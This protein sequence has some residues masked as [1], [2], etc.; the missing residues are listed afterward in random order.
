MTKSES[1]RNWRKK[2]LIDRFRKLTYNDKCE[3]ILNMKIEVL[4]LLAVIQTE[5]LTELVAKKQG[6]VISNSDLKA[7]KLV[8]GY[9]R[10]VSLRVRHVRMTWERGS[11]RRAKCT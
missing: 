8:T 5:M 9:D 2:A 1:L 7:T 3:W 4:I 6:I 10:V 11:L